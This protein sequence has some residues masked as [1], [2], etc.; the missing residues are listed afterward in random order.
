MK[1]KRNS[2][3]QGASGAF[4]K[5]LVFRQR[6]GKTV[7]SRPASIKPGPP[8]PQQKVLRDKFREAHLFAKTVIADPA[9]KAIYQAKAK[10]GATAYNAAISEFMKQ[11]AAAVNTA[12]DQYAAT[13]NTGTHQ[14]PVIHIRAPAHPKAATI[15]II[16]L[17]ADGQVLETGTALP[18][19][20]GNTSQ[21]IK[22]TVHKAAQPA[23]MKEFIYSPQQRYGQ[24]RDSNAHIYY[25]FPQN[26]LRNQT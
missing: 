11:H 13:V 5:E 19:P 2:I 25:R 12:I 15:K 24:P 9:L 4:G 23:A 22:R 1:Q 10:P 6:G 16:M 18:I 14:P 26:L 20:A 21:A 17:D 3:M 7:I 8:S